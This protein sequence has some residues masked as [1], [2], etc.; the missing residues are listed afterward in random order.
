[1][2]QAGTGLFGQKGKCA[3]KWRG[4]NKIRPELVFR[5][6]DEKCSH[7]P[8]EISALRS[9]LVFRELPGQLVQGNGQAQRLRRWLGLRRTLIEAVGDGI[10]W[11]A[12]VPTG[13]GFLSAD[14][15]ALWVA[16]GML[17]ISY[18]RVRPE[19]PAA[20]EA[21]SLPSLWHRD[22]PSWSSR[23]DRLT[24]SGQ[25]RMPGSL[26]ASIGGSFL[27]SAEGLTN[28]TCRTPVVI[29]VGVLVS[30]TVRK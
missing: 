9:E 2:R 8:N 1:M 14:G 10:V 22:D 28:E 16:A 12:A 6:A 4:I 29:G 3:G 24:G 20:D 26:L 5:G 25:F 19:P 11:V 18:P 13:L 30:M 21:W 17:A 15:L 7:K 23:P 27:A